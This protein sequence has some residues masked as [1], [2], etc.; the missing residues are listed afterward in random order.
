MLKLTSF[1]ADVEVWV[2]P[3]QIAYMECFKPLA[4][5]VIDLSTTQVPAHTCIL[6]KAGKVIRVK[7]TGQDII[8]MIAELNK[9]DTTWLSKF[10][11]ED[12]ELQ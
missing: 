4:S 2:A 3:D 8:N 12:A 5:A 11:L 6:L 1:E 9:I 10:G 7:E